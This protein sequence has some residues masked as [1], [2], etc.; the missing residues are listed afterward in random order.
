MAARRMKGVVKP[1]HAPTIK[2]PRIQRKR[3]GCEAEGVGVSGSIVLVFD[4]RKLICCSNT[5]RW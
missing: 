3:E 4:T 5:M 2:K 1:Q